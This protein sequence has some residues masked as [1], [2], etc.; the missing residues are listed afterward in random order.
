MAMASE[1][2]SR[3]DIDACTQEASRAT[4]AD[5]DAVAIK[6]AEALPND[7]L[8]F[9]AVAACL[10]SKGYVRVQDIGGVCDDFILPQCFERN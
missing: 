10:N 3:Q 4:S 8:L 1:N 7:P 9:E 2:A 5:P 6:Q